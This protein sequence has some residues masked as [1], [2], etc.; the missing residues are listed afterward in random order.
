MPSLPYDRIKGSFVRQLESLGLVSLDTSRHKILSEAVDSLCASLRKMFSEDEPEAKAAGVKAAPEASAD[1]ATAWVDDLAPKLP[2]PW[3][4]RVIP[5]AHMGAG[6]AVFAHY[7][8]ATG[9]P[10]HGIAHV[11][12]IA[13]DKRIVD[14]RFKPDEGQKAFDALVG[15]A[16]SNYGKPEPDDRAEP[17]KPSEEADAG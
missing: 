14:V 3:K 2:E 5:S 6:R 8:V 15:F 16:I 13:P 4:F 10:V 1:D 9:T 12:L 7:D 11:H 17:E